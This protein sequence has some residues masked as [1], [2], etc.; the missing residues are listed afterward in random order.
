MND[1]N[2]RWLERIRLFEDDI[3]QDAVLALLFL[4]HQQIVVQRAV[5]VHGHQADVP[6][7]DGVVHQLDGVDVAFER[8]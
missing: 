3:Q 2:K 4:Q 1:A 5:G 7:V 6:F 8:V